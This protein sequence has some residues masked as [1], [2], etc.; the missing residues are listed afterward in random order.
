MWTV[1]QI[2]ASIQRRAPAIALFIGDCLKGLG[3]L[4]LAFFAG[5]FLLY[6]VYLCVS[7]PVHPALWRPFSSPSFENAPS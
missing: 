1:P 4:I 6:L 7:P 5:I 2:A 3:G